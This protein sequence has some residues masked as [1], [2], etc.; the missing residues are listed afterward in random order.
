MICSQLKLWWAWHSSAPACFIQFS[1]LP[2]PYFPFSQFSPFFQ[3]HLPHNIIYPNFPFVQ[4]S[5]FPLSI[6]TLWDTCLFCYVC[7]SI[8]YIFHFSMNFP[9]LELLTQPKIKTSLAGSATLGD[10]SWARL[11]L[12]SWN[13]P[14]SQSKTELEWHRTTLRGGH[15]TEKMCTRRGGDTAHTLLMGW[16]I[17]VGTPHNI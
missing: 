5:I 9:F 11:H 1:F 16:T 15:R 2:V 4:F 17:R 13:L 12:A 10:T 14:D 7:L 8:Y 3:T 6:Q